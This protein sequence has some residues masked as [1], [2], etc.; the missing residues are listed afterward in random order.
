MLIPAISEYPSLRGAGKSREFTLYIAP[1]EIMEGFWICFPAGTLFVQR[2]GRSRQG[3]ASFF[4]A[5]ADAL[6]SAS[7][8]RG[9]NDGPMGIS[10]FFRSGEEPLV[11]RSG[12]V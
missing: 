11:R 4:Y 3:T 10:P 9:N 2:E 1:L 6:F 5:V 8:A 12:K 7:G